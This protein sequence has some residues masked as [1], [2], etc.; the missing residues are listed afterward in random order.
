VLGIGCGFVLAATVVHAWA[1]INSLTYLTFNRPVALPGVTLGSG[2]YAFEIVNPLDSADIVRVRDRNRTKVY[3]SGMTISA[4]RPER[5][6]SDA[7]VWFG[8][9]GAHDPVQIVAWFPPN[10]SR[11]RQFLYGK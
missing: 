3:F 11:G 9:T 6:A 10:A 8:E 2:T 1:P 5:L 4:K 7:A